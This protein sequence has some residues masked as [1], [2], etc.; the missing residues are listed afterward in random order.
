[1]LKTVKNVDSH[2]EFLFQKCI[3][4]YCSFEV[5]VHL[6]KFFIKIKKIIILPK[7]LEDKNSN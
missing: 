6:F 4:F 2:I 5:F 1:M 3:F 7:T